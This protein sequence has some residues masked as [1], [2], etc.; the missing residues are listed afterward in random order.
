MKVPDGTIL[1]EKAV[2]AK[3]VLGYDYP[4][5]IS[6]YPVRLSSDLKQAT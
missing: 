4:L 6:T 1:L 2:M 3:M 5:I